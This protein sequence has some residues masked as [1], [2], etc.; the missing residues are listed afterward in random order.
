[1]QV[2]RSNALAEANGD[3]NMDGAQGPSRFT[4]TEVVGKAVEIPVSKLQDPLRTAARNEALGRIAKEAADKKL[5]AQLMSEDV[6]ATTEVYG[7][8]SRAAIFGGAELLTPTRP[9]NGS[10]EAASIGR[11]VKFGPIAA[12]SRESTL[13]LAHQGTGQR[14][15]GR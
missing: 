11:G 6:A 10:A 9:S 8:A 13:R 5:D 2:E 4:G 15:P 7:R 12:A 1:M 14:Q 3:W